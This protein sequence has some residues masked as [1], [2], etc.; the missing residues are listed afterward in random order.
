MLGKNVEKIRLRVLGQKCHRHDSKLFV[1]AKIFLRPIFKS[2][3][4]HFG[5]VFVIRKAERKSL[6]R[7]IKWNSQRT[8]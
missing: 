5:Q 6:H 3:E 1:Q 8:H 7:N 4:A 2:A